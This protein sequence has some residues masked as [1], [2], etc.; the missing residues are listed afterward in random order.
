MMTS[1]LGRPHRVG[2]PRAVPA[3]SCCAQSRLRLEVTFAAERPGLAGQGAAPEPARKSQAGR[4]V[5]R[6]HAGSVALGSPVTIKKSAS[7]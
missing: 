3:T 4:G 2:R 5:V 7:S 6:G 1:R